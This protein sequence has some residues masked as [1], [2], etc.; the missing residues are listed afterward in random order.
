MDS[1]ADLICINEGIIPQNVQERPQVSKTTNSER[2][3]IRYKLSNS[4]ICN[5]ICIPQKF[6]MVKDLAQAIILGNSSIYSLFP[7]EQITTME[8]VLQNLK[9]HYFQ[10]YR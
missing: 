5:N 7:I 3:A 9:K 6:V 4:S 2:L 1:G 8:L 10:V